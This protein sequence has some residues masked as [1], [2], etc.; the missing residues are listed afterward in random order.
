MASSVPEI[1]DRV[2][3]TPNPKTGSLPPAHTAWVVFAHWTVS[4]SVPSGLLPVDCTFEVL[5]EAACSALKELGPPHAG[6][7]SA[8]FNPFR[9]DGWFPDEPVWCVGYAHENIVTI[10]T[11]DSQPMTAG[12]SGRARR[13]LD[14]AE[15]SIVFVRS[16]AEAGRI[17]NRVAGSHTRLDP[18]V[19][20]VHSKGRSFVKADPAI[21]KRVYA[22][23]LAGVYPQYIAKAGRRPH[24]SRVDQIIRSPD[25]PRGHWTRFR[26]SA[27]TSR[28]S[29][30]KPR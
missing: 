12:L 26:R 30:R 27:R 2:F 6:T 19:G 16:G 9:L 11:M 20:A 4:Y 8:D 10:V 23:S 13:E 1:L 3:T 22:M 24:E 18:T 14:L 25:T 15:Q 17:S 28:R 29:S 7:E 21:L 5:A